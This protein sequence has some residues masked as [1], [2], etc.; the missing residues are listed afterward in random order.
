MKRKLARDLTYSALMS[1]AMRILRRDGVT[2][3]WLTRERAAVIV[4]ADDARR[5]QA[6]R[7]AA[8]VPLVLFLRALAPEHEPPR[9]HAAAWRERHPDYARAYRLKKAEPS[10]VEPS[11]WAEIVDHFRARCYV[12]SAPATR[13]G[14]LEDAPRTPVPACRVHEARP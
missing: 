7:A 3:P 5:E 4:G 11:V 13:V 2:N 10:G 6:A 12:C 9:D 8:L 1:R 14:R